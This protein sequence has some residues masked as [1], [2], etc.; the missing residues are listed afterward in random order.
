MASNNLTNEILR[1]FDPQIARSLIEFG[2]SLSDIDAD[3]LV[4]MA[5]RAYC[6]YDV[7]VR[8]GVPPARQYVVSDRVLDMRLTP[9]E[10]KRVALV[11]DTLILGQTLSKAKER[12][13][14]A[15]AE[16]VSVHVFAAD[17]D[18][19][20]RPL[21]TPE[22]TVMVRM[23]H[24][25]VMTFCTA[26]V[27]AL[28]LAPRPY[29]VDFPVTEPIRID[30]TELQ[31]IL[32]ST[33]WNGFRIPTALQKRHGIDVYTF[34]PTD[35]VRSEMRKGLG[36]SLF[37]RLD[38]VKIRA[39]MRKQGEGYQLQLVPLVTLKT[40]LKSEVDHVI[41][42]LLG[43][44]TVDQ[45]KERILDFA[46]AAKPRQRLA[47][48]FLSAALGQHFG[49]TLSRSIGS[50]IEIRYDSKETAHH[51]GPWLHREMAEAEANSFAGL[52]AVSDQHQAT[53][54]AAASPADLP[55]DIK[56]LTSDVF[57]KTDRGTGPFTAFAHMFLNLHDKFEETARKEVRGEPVP[58]PPSPLKKW[59]DR[60]EIGIPWTEIV[61]RLAPSKGPGHARD[62]MN[63][64][65]LYLDHLVDLGIAVPITCEYGDVV[66]RAYR[67][68]EDVKF[69]ATEAAL[70]SK[71]IAG[72]CEA[73]GEKVIPKLA[74]EKLLVLFIRLGAAQDFL[75]PFYG[76]PVE[77]EMAKVG[78]DLMGAVA[79][80][81]E[82]QGREIW[83]SKHLLKLN[84]IAKPNKTEA[85]P[86]KYTYCDHPEKP[87][88]GNF[89]T[90]RAPLQAFQLGLIVGS[91]RPSATR[92]DA[93][94]DDKALTILAS[95]SSPNDTAA[96]L[97]AELEIFLHWYTGHRH[98]LLAQDWNQID[99]VVSG[100]EQITAGRGHTAV[101]SAKLKFVA[102]MN[103]EC[104]RII[105]RAQEALRPNLVASSQWAQYWVM[106]GTQLVREKALFD[107]LIC[108]AGVKCWE[109]AT[110]LSAMEVA[111]RAGLLSL[112]SRGSRRSQGKAAFKLAVNKY[113]AYRR[114][115][116]EARLRSPSSVA[117]LI[118]HLDAATTAGTEDFDYRSTYCLAVSSLERC[119]DD[120]PSLVER[121]RQEVERFGRQPAHQYKCFLKYK[122]HQQ[123]ASIE[124]TEEFR[125]SVVSRLQR[126]TA[127]AR[128]DGGEVF[129]WAESKDSINDEK[130]VFFDGEAA[131]DYARE[132]MAIL[133]HGTSLQP[134]VR[135]SIYAAP[136]GLIGTR[137]YRYRDDPEVKGM[138][139]KLHWDRLLE[140][141]SAIEAGCSQERSFLLVAG[142]LAGTFNAPDGT[143]WA[144]TPRN[145]RV[146]TEHDTRVRETPVLFGEAYETLDLSAFRVKPPPRPTQ[147]GA[148]YAK[149]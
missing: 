60:L 136:C 121:L 97:G 1:L 24:P 100:H 118:R 123:A 44:I 57:P 102:Y 53:A 28:S 74:L 63:R 129:C 86:N 30:A 13:L 62:K 92:E 77:P 14:D 109:L 7:L 73:T 80:H 33:E 114:D 52:W 55:S 130:Y 4:F 66:F 35:D 78:F 43:R 124:K 139:F 26:A 101:Y 64:L 88:E 146:R 112:K 23:G 94:L 50:P 99:S 108:E 125:Q 113:Q 96:A 49:R 133:I 46:Q 95:C 31:C 137:V 117:E 107:P 3:Y 110:C 16:A 76:P 81:R 98:K 20:H 9:F 131:L 32:T 40:L 119:L 90:P 27:R 25:Q 72:F 21:L 41:S 82:R 115:M 47:Q 61:K 91:L 120:A 11:D 126:L 12:L 22:P 103:G 84:I 93:P 39:F 138:E 105:E 45:D 69:S 75:E 10:G 128:A 116:M 8:I 144:A 111:L 140:E 71:A 36:K 37:S 135:A 68:G 5:R 51:Y 85:K 70:A 132:A 145:E 48:Y 127:L 79:K 83:L 29:L 34:F 89:A 143:T 38:I 134:R 17:D 122:I 149:G 19:R 106:S 65:S 6:L 67:Y 141:C 148:P 142:D 87:D 147:A 59:R 54:Q 18:T 58:P 104:Q 56:Q 15:G 42:S 2:N